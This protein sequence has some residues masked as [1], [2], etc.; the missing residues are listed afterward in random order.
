MENKPQGKK[1][2]LFKI[3]KES[4][5][6]APKV[7]EVRPAFSLAMVNPLCGSGDQKVNIDSNLNPNLNFDNFVEY[8]K[9]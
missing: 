9:Q 3:I 2:L 1:N 5:Y 7:Q 8:E 6:K 4:L